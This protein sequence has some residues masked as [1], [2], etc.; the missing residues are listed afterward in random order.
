MTDKRQSTNRSDAAPRRRKSAATRRTLALGT[1]AATGVVVAG[2]GDGGDRVQTF[3]N[4]DACQKAGFSKYICDVQYQEALARHLR[5]APRYGT[6][7]ACEKVFGPNKCYETK[8]AAQTLSNWQPT[9]QNQQT[10][11]TSTFL[12]FLSGFMV[13]QS[14]RSISS[15][16]GYY[17]W[18]NDYPGYYSE[19]IY[20]NRTG[21]TVT[22]RR[23]RAGRPATVRPANVN[24]R[25]VSRRGFGGRSS[26]RGWGG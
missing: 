16:Y 23:G 9:A 1:I 18:R 11:S 3:A 2:C 19:P 26:R 13:A 14:L 6:K 20:R 5:N 15:S 25:T 17:R 7:E 8:G 22:A 4:I 24:T 10:Q 21:E 12:P